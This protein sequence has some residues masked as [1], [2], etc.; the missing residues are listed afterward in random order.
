MINIFN[1]YFHAENSSEQA[2]DFSESLDSFQ[3][4]S[5]DFSLRA[6][7]PDSRSFPDTQFASAQRYPFPQY[8]QFMGRFPYPQEPPF[9]NSLIRAQPP[10][11]QQT[12][13][14]Q[15]DQIPY[16]FN[17]MYPMTY[18]FRP[19][20]FP[21]RS[22]HPRPRHPFS[23]RAPRPHAPRPS[24]PSIPDSQ[25]PV[26]VTDP[27]YTLDPLGSGAHLYRCTLCSVNCNSL[28][29]WESHVVGR[30]HTHQVKLHK[31]SRAP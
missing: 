26:T 20:S 5:L 4:S 17:Q 1:R 9:S 30:K 2:A 12:S 6:P 25:Q 22:P 24:P 28:Q 31:G 15:G 14:G 19:Q 23:S 10:M 8:Q 18:N 11:Q 3:N 29:M 16:Q 13:Y 21:Q 7:Y 27:V